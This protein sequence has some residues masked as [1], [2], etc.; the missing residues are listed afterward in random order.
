MCQ[1][2]FSLAQK[3]SNVYGKIERE[4]AHKRKFIEQSK[5]KKSNFWCACGSCYNRRLVNSVDLKHPLFI[6][7]NLLS[8]LLSPRFSMFEGR[9]KQFFFL[10]VLFTS[11]L[12]LPSFIIIIN[13]SLFYEGRTLSAANIFN[14]YSHIIHYYYTHHY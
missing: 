13:L 7:A 4:N 5:K 8:L 3:L 6:L 1:L 14:L 2:F 9:R 11:Q 10:F 12:T